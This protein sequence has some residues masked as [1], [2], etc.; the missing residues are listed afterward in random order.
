MNLY[1][2]VRALQKPQWRGE[3]FYVQ[4]LLHE[5]VRIGADHCFHLHFGWDGWDAR[6]DALL[7]APNVV[8]HDHRGRIRSHASLPLAVMR[9]RSRVYFRMYNEDAPLRVPVPCRRVALVLDNGRHLLPHEYGGTDAAKLR[10]ARRRH[11]R[12]FDLIVTISETVKQEIVELLD[13]DA[14]RI[15][16]ASCAVDRPDPEASAERPAAVPQGASFVLM[17][18][19]G[20]AN[21]N[22]RDALAGF[23]R[24]ARGADGG[25]STLLVLAGGLATERE[26]IG[27]AIAADPVLADR[28]VCPGYVSD[29]ELRWLYR[30]ARLALYP[31][32]YEGF[33]IPVLEAFAHGVPLIAADIPVLREVAGSAAQFVALGDHAGMAAA[34]D[35]LLADGPLRAGLVA[36]GHAR[37]DAYS[38]RDSAATALQA[39]LELAGGAS[40]GARQGRDRR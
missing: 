23:A 27:E 9:S 29:E 32:R 21:K 17:V 15:V 30:H 4:R 25:G 35:R 5:M 10:S 26:R 19:P 16:V 12:A 37:V 33:G 34:I 8:A 11:I 40:P 28:V 22:W 2:D 18:N 38:W 36:R 13:V 39:L 3:Q 31:S 20:G 1:L 14:D 7:A 6:I 24:F